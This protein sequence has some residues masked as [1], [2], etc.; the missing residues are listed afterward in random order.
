MIELSSTTL[1]FGLGCFETIKVYQ[2]KQAGFLNQHIA[3]LQHG[4]KV[5]G[6][7]CP[8]QQELVL[9]IKNFLSKSTFSGTQ[10]LRLVLTKEHGATP[11]IEPYQE[12]SAVLKLHTSHIWKIESGSPLNCFKSFNYLKNHLAHQEALNAGFDDSLLLNE[13]HQ[14]VESSRANL[15]F[16]LPG[17][18]WLTPSLA[19]GC[20]PGIIRAHLMGYLQA[21]E[22]TIL[23]KDLSSFKYVLAVSSLVEV[24]SVIAIDDQS[25]E[26]S[27]LEPIKAYIKE[28]AFNDLT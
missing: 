6:L 9:L 11:F 21:K 8:N 28:K 27:D 23:P 12:R 25:F 7:A 13:H 19:S 14:I 1:R 4:A 18:S 26:A 15:F 16:G 22:A 17:G 10:I 2:N 24:Q 5:C 3:R 20:L